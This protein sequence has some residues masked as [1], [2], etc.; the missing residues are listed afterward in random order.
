[1]PIKSV[2]NKSCN[3]SRYLYSRSTG[4]VRGPRAVHWGQGWGVWLSFTTCLLCLYSYLAV[5]NR[6]E[7]DQSRR[8]LCVVPVELCSA[9]RPVCQHP[10][11]SHERHRSKDA[12][13]EG[14]A[15][16]HNWGPQVSCKPGK[17]PPPDLFPEV[18]WVPRV[19]PEPSVEQRHFWLA[20]FGQRFVV[21]HEHTELIVGKVRCRQP[22]NAPE[23]TQEVVVVERGRRGVHSVRWQRNPDQHWLLR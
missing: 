15:G 2:T 11:L 4:E 8:L 20:G 1:M 5:L 22:Q 10:F 19:S 23:C 18:I 16:K 21:Q 9:L 7:R 3:V 12:R 17:G 14:S 13:V 6:E